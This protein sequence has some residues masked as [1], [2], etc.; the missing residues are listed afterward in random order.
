M[1]KKKKFDCVTMK[2]EIQAKMYEETKEMSNEALLR[3]YHQAVEKGPFAEKMK[4]IRA[5]QEKQKKVG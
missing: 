1:N 3:Y 5:R 2:L 4:R